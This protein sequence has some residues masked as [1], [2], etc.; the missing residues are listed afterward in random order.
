MGSVEYAT[1]HLRVNL[2]GT[3]FECTFSDQDFR[4]PD[5]GSTQGSRCKGRGESSDRE[6]RLLDLDDLLLPPKA[7]D[8]L[9]PAGENGGICDVEPVKA[10]PLPKV[11]HSLNR[12]IY[13][14]VKKLGIDRAVAL[15]TDG[16]IGT[17]SGEVGGNI[18]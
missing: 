6:R 10:E 5:I 15:N 2:G 13:R 9:V 12:I 3:L 14:I 1:S 11:V 7:S 4:P 8:H 17:P 18:A 16:L